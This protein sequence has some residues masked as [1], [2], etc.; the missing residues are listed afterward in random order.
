MTVNAKGK[1]TILWISKLDLVG[2]LAGAVAI[3]GREHVVRVIVPPLID[4]LGNSR[5]SMTL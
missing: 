4:S 5:P 2:G 1:E 3:E